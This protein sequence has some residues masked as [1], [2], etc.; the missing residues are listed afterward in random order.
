M[1]DNYCD[2]EGI[3]LVVFML[4]QGSRIFWES[5]SHTPSPGGIDVYR[6]YVLNSRAFLLIFFGLNQGTNWCGPQSLNKLFL[7]GLLFYKGSVTTIKTMFNKSCVRTTNL[8][9]DFVFTACCQTLAWFAARVFPSAN[10]YG[11]AVQGTQGSFFSCQDFCI[12]EF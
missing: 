2:P 3:E 4:P 12:W 7:S 9:I 8:K 5:E 6:S 1:E 10:L 11:S